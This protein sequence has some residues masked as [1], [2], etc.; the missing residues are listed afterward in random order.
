MLCN[1]SYIYRVDSLIWGSPLSP[2]DGGAVTG[3]IDP[4]F[5][6][7]SLQLL[8][9]QVVSLLTGVIFPLYFTLRSLTLSRKGMRQRCGRMEIWGE[10]TVARFWAWT[11]SFHQL[12]KGP[13]NAR[14]CVF[15]LHVNIFLSYKTAT[16]TH[17][18]S[19][20]QVA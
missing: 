13:A 15:L 17:S 16:S 2:L 1:V 12:G 8:T 3:P 10:K 7:Y 4:P 11:C 6:N 19:G 5:P 20:A 14:G 18:T 9:L